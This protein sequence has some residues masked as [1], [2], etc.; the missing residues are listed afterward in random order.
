MKKK[1]YIVYIAVFL[2]LCC[3][4]MA[5][6]PF[7]GSGKQI[8]NEKENPFPALWTENGLNNG[9]SGECDAWFSK[10]NPLRVPL[11]NAE[12][13]IRLSLMKS[14]SNGVIQGKHNYLFS[15]E[16]VGDYIGTS[17]TRRALYRAA[18]TVSLTQAAA[19]RMGSRFVFTVTPNK[20]TLYPQYMPDRFIRGKSS[21][22]SV[23]ERYLAQL[24]VNYVDMKQALPYR[25][26]ELYLRDDT[27]WNN[28]GAL[29]GSNAV[30]DALEKTHDNGEGMAYMVKNDWTGDLTKMAFPDS[31]RTCE[32]FYF[33]YPTDFTFMQPHGGETAAILQEVMGDSEKRDAQIR[34]SNP[35]AEGSLYFLR[36]SFGR[37]MLPYFINSYKSATITRY[38]PISLRGGFDDVVWQIVERNIPN[39]LTTAPRVDAVPAEPAASERVVNSADNTI[40]VDDSVEGSLKLCGTVDRILLSDECNLYLVLRSDSTTLCYEAFP[41]YEAETLG[42]EDSDNGFSLTL[43]TKD[44]PNGSYRLCVMTDGEH[45]AQTQTLYT[46]TK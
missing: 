9:F 41:I 29:Y 13:T 22:L 18:K 42:G 3:I 23:L 36:D 11:I 28:L 33:D 39:I 34:T 20:N 27:H 24:G 30:L 40:E 8:G 4:P 37:A 43:N 5:L 21:N 26:D 1:L 19:Q 38:Y 14:D 2:L 15:E 6:K 25:S 7:V 44:I 45:A 32:Q 35:G 10:E 31:S 46:Y 16:T 17:M 12:N